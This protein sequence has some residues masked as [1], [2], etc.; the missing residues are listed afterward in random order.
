MLRHL[1]LSGNP[2]SASARKSIE[3]ELVLC[4]LRNA[5]VTDI[6]CRGF[7]DGDASRIADA[8]R[9]AFGFESVRYVIG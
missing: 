3:L 9:C 6:A 7:D 5:A 8:L 4:Q 2:M 1:E